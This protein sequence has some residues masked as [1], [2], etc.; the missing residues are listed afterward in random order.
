[1]TATG[2]VRKDVLSAQLAQANTQD[3]H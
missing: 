1:M 3:A 2:K